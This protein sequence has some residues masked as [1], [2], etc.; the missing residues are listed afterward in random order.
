MKDSNGMPQDR[1]GA[2]VNLRHIHC[3]VLEDVSTRHKINRDKVEKAWSYLNLTT[4][5]QF[6]DQ[7]SSSGPWIQTLAKVQWS[8]QCLELAACQAAEAQWI[9]E[10][11]ILC[12]E[13]RKMQNQSVETKDQF[14][15]N[16]M[17]WSFVRGRQK[18]WALTNPKDMMEIKVPTKA[19][20]EPRRRILLVQREGRIYILVPRMTTRFHT[21]HA[22]CFFG[23]IAVFGQPLLTTRCAQKTT[24]NTIYI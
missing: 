21:H 22:A 5:W 3:G 11:L 16:Q 20:V 15:K 13:Y 8:Q 7:R 19:A 1:Q 23:V 18:C 12:C 4:K 14:F 17:R 6:Q 10:V 2:S 24:M 9:E